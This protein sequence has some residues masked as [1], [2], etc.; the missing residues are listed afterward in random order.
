MATNNNTVVIADGSGNVKMGFTN[1]GAMFVGSNITN[2]GANGQVLQSFGPGGAPNWVNPASITVGTGTN[3]LNSY[4][5]DDSSTGN[6]EYV[7]F[8]NATNTYTGMRSNSASFTYQ[9]NIGL[10]TTPSHYISST[11]ANTATTSSNALYVAG[12]SY[13]NSLFVLNQ[14]TFAGPVVFNGTATY[15]YSTNTVYTDNIIELH[16]PPGGVNG[17]WAYDDGKDIG[18]RFHYFNR[19]IS[20]DSNAA[21]VLADDSQ[22]LEFYNLGAESNTGTFSAGTPTY[23]TFKTG[24]IKLVGGTSATSITS[25][26]MTVTGGVGI[27]KSLYV[28]GSIVLNGSPLTTQQAMTTYEFTSGINSSTFTISGGYTVGQIEVYSNG[29]LMNSGD[30]VATNGSTV[31]FNAPRNQG[32]LISVR[33]FVSFGVAGSTM[34]SKSYATAIATAMGM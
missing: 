4:V 27:G 32:D 15:V 20:T 29:V 11:A 1:T 17:Q 21:L 2:F 6:P 14:T 31:V 18:L 12:G 16:A 10:L 19:S 26:D 7:T 22:Y 8:V 30:Y 33:T 23:G 3:A 24:A 25:G 13:L 5:T 9:P 34:A 28:N